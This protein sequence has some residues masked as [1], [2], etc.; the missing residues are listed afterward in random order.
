MCIY[1]VECVAHYETDIETN[2]IPL[3]M[4]ISPRV[5]LSLSLLS[6]STVVFTKFFINILLSSGSA[7]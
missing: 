7:V 4:I 2:D 5:R 1:V 6:S 3:G